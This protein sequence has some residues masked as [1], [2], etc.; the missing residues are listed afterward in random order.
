MAF[1]APGYQPTVMSAG[2]NTN[3][4]PRQNAV[5]L[6]TNCT[7]LHIISYVA[8]ALL[9]CWCAAVLQLCCSKLLR[10]ATMCY[11]VCHHPEVYELQ[12]FHIMQHLRHTVQP[13]ERQTISNP[14]HIIHRTAHSTQHTPQ[15][16]LVT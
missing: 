3:S 14:A 2:K 11:N 13:A 9:L 8:T 12:S 15:T 16:A 6:Q 7:S 10:C 4:T 5:L 1:T